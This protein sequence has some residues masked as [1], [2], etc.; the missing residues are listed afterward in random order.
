VVR[1]GDYYHAERMPWQ[2]RLDFLDLMRCS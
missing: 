1:M 2:A